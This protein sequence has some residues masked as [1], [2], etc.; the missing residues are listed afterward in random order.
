MVP[1]IIYEDN[2]IIVVNKP[3]GILSQGDSSGSESMLEIL[4][5]YIKKKYN[6]PG[7]VFL[8]LVHR[9]DMPVS[10]LMVFAKTSKAAGRMFTEI[11]SGS[12][13]KYYVAII[14]KNLADYGNWHILENFLRRQRDITKIIS[15]GNDDADKAVLYYRTILSSGQNSLVLIK[16]E[17]GK[18]HQIRAQFAGIDA[19]VAGDRKYGSRDR[20]DAISLHAVYLSF[21]HPTLKQ[22]MEFS[23][24]IPGRFKNFMPFD[25][26]KV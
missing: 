13:G 22:R 18:K 6:R 24:E 20:S 8:G 12:M 3:A 19:P 9:L 23:T 21:S 15:R 16:L 7:N 17:T 11:T 10:G 2:H 5:D 25:S 14:E 4:K 26:D 1:E